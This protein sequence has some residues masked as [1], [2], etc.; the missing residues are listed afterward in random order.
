M[1]AGAPQPF[2]R[3]L[4]PFVAALIAVMALAAAP[5]SAAL[6]GSA[7]GQ[8]HAA[9]LQAASAAKKAAAERR[10]RATRRRGSA[11][12]CATRPRTCRGARKPAP[13]TALAPTPFVPLSLPAPAAPAPAL[14]APAPATQNRYVSVQ[15]REFYYTLSR[16]VVA[17]GRVTFELR[18][19][20]ED[21]HNLVVSP[22]GTHEVLA[23]FAELAPGSVDRRERELA[24]GRYLLWCSLDGHEAIGM[25]ATLRVE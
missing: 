8:A 21:P 25:K 19:A 9:S 5:A 1:Q 15:A 22:E 16:P 14:E 7:S 23:S 6:S 17:A 4:A 12:R 11:G 10:R 24:P 13:A 20:G 3:V 2:R 18:N